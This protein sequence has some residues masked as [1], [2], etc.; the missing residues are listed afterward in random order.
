M[1]NP[2]DLPAAP[3]AAP[4]AGEDVAVSPSIVAP[5][6]ARADAIAAATGGRTFGFGLGSARAYR[7]PADD[8]ATV[9]SDAMRDE[10]D[11]HYGPE[12]ALVRSVLPA[13]A[14]GQFTAQLAAARREPAGSDPNVDFADLARAS[15]FGTTD[16]EAARSASEL[17]RSVARHGA[18]PVAAAL[19]LATG[20]VAAG[21][22]AGAAAGA[23][24]PH[25]DRR[26][27]ERDGEQSRRRREPQTA[28]SQSESEAADDAGYTIDDV[29]R[30]SDRVVA[31]HR[32]DVRSFPWHS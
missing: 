8:S 17:A 11:R 27:L 4:V 9:A 23:N 21:V 20:S 7:G 22:P 12:L 3:A 5:G 10:L 16:A 15:V 1:L 18:A 6:G 32:Q 26:A 28:A 30:F 29:V 2:I 19:H 24:P 14:Q 13:G 25:A 31:I